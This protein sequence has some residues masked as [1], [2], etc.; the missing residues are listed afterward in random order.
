VD[1]I[2]IC[3]NWVAFCGYWCIIL[4]HWM[5]YKW[6]YRLMPFWVGHDAMATYGNLVGD[7]FWTL[8]PLVCL[9]L[10]DSIQQRRGLRRKRRGGL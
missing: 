5:P 4:P 8:E 7:V 6:F 10:P 9:Y 2:A 1:N 3:C